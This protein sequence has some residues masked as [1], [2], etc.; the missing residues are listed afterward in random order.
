MSW[1][2][3]G[4]QFILLCLTHHRVGAH[5][6]VHKRHNHVPLVHDHQVVDRLVQIFPKEIFLSHTQRIDQVNQAT[7]L[8]VQTAHAAI[9]NHALRHLDLIAVDHAQAVVVAVGMALRLVVQ[10]LAHVQI[11]QACAR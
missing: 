1:F 9:H 11:D 5:F 3:S 8:I 6:R 4:S 7:P 2:T 10:V